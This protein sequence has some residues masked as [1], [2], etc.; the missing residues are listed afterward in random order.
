[1]RS[2]SLL[3]AFLLPTSLVLATSSALAQSP[4]FGLGRTPTEQEVRAW[5]I[6]IHPVTG[7]ELPPG[8][9]TATEGALLYRR[10]C[11]R[12]HGADGTEGRAP[13]LV[14]QDRPEGTHPWNLG[15]ILPIR[16]PYAPTVWDYI[17]RGMPL[18]REG[19]LTPDEVYALT[20]L[21]LYWNGIIGEEEAMTHQTL[22]L[23]QMP[24]RD[25]WAPLPDWKPGQPRW[26][27]YPY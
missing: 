1:M 8:S 22:P 27:G 6:S 11:A 9:G 25:A 18:N 14:K 12:C 3:A 21:L 24:N 17:N 23:V 26:P 16:S 5:D 7:A 13:R 10:H 15:R 4:T 19:T 2:S 20:A